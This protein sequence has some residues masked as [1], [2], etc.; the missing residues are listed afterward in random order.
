[1]VKAGNDRPG[2][3][4]PPKV[5]VRPSAAAVT[6]TA[7][8]GIVSSVTSNVSSCPADAE[9]VRVAFSPAVPILT[10]AGTPIVAV[11]VLAGTAPSR[12]VKWPVSSPDGSTFTVYVP[13]A[14]TANV[15]KNR[16]GGVTPP[17]V[18]VRPSAAAIT[19]TVADGI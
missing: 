4:T 19:V 5:S 1:M 2:G 8:D 16:P 17:E 7:A 6:V 3:V 10:A 15:S 11:P 9:N 12:N 13:S 18:S 14:G